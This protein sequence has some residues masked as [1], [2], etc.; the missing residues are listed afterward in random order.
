MIEVSIKN[1]KKEIKVTTLT[2]NNKIDR[3]TGRKEMEMEKKKKK[4][5]GE[6]RLK[7]KKNITMEHF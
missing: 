2:R 6:K 3:K 7:G 1:N 5:R 4:R